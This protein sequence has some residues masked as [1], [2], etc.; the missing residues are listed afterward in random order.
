V[1]APQQESR[2][3]E[4]HRHREV[5][6]AEQPAVDTAGVPGLKRHVRDDDADR[7][8]GAHALDGGQEVTLPSGSGRIGHG[9][10]CAGRSNG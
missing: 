6:A 10:Q 9:D 8:A 2:Q 5:E 1:P 7:G 3:R 4:E